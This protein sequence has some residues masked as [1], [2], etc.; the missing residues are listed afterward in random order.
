MADAPSAMFEHYLR[1]DGPD[2]TVE[3]VAGRGSPTEGDLGR[4]LSQKAVWMFGEQ[5]QAWLMSRF[6]RAYEAHKV[7]PKGA[8]VTLHVE[9]DTDSTLDPE[10]GKG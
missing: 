10:R 5:A 7:M 9:L 2:L 4:T 6:M 8:K 3:I 1:T